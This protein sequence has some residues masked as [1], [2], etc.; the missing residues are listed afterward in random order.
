MNKYIAAICTLVV[1]CCSSAYIIITLSGQTQTQALG[2][3]GILLIS[4]AILVAI[5]LR[6]EE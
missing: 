4:T 5:E 3:T 2:I 6:E 1:A